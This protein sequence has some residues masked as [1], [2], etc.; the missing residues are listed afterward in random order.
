MVS[1][2]GQFKLSDA[3]LSGEAK[4]LESLGVGIGGAT[5]L[6]PGRMERWNAGKLKL[7]SWNPG[8]LESW[9]AGTLESWEAA[10]V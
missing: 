7:G 10:A 4:G 6:A 9:D 8:I 1:S 3:V 5:G 2:S